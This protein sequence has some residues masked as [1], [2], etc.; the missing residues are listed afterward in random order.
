MLEGD[1][2]RAFDRMDAGARRHE[3]KTRN[4]IHL[5]VEVVQRANER[6]RSIGIVR[7]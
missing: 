5:H 6:E 2:R 7:S 1:Q 4:D 3:L